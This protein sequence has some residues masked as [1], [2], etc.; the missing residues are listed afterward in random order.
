MST[1]PKRRVPRLQVH[2][3]S[4]CQESWSQMA[5][6][7][8]RRHCERCNH[9]VHDLS[10]LSPAAAHALVAN[11]KPGELCVRGYFTADGTPVTHAEMARRRTRRTSTRGAL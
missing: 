5:G 11:A 2:I 1:P 9:K 3:P 8:Q 7:A 4:P 6:D 10:A